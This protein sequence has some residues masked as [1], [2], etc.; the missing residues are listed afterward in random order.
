MET[1]QLQQA[2][3]IF[4]VAGRRKVLILTCAFLGVTLGLGVYLKDI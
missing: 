4:D 1:R 2:R 3:K